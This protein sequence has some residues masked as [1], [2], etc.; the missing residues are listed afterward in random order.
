VTDGWWIPLLGT[1][2]GV[3]LQIWII[4]RTENRVRGG[5]D[6][7]IQTHEDRLGKMEAE[8]SLVKT[9]FDLER[10]A[11]DERYETLTSRIGEQG[12]ALRQHIHQ[13]EVWMRDHLVSKDTF[14]TVINKLDSRFDR[15]DA[16]LDKLSDSG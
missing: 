4:S 13:I 3:V 15:L 14:T 2:F 12:V 11:M 6:N 10:R 1:A 5:L 7:T 9:R 8:V 16:K